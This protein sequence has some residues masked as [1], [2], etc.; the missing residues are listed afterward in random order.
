MHPCKRREKKQRRKA[1]RNEEK[2]EKKEREPAGRA[3]SPCAASCRCGTHLR[4]CT[5]TD[6]PGQRAS[7][8]Y[9]KQERYSTLAPER[10]AC[11]AVRQPAGINRDRS[12]YAPIESLV[13]RRERPRHIPAHPLWARDPEGARGKSPRVISC[14]IADT[15]PNGTSP[16]E[17]ALAT[18]PRYKFWL[19]SPNHIAFAEEHDCDGNGNYQVE[20]HNQAWHN[21]QRA[22]QA[23]K[24]DRRHAATGGKGHAG[25]LALQGRHR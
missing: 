3:P 6:T 18:S 12:I 19:Y 1:E 24:L 8:R 5:L 10:I 9:S 13:K 25:D 2:R 21:C 4:P 14:L 11:V 7:P 15:D 23:R 22:P 17:H 16:Y 20:D